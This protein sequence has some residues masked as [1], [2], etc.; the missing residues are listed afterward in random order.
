MCG[1]YFV[2]RIKV[3]FRFGF[4]MLVWKF[5]SIFENL[6]CLISGWGLVVIGSM[7]IFMGYYVWSRLY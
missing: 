7:V 3:R 5:K 2:L 6:I 1:F 4:L